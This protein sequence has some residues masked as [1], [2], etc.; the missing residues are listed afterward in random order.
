MTFGNVK[1]I[2]EKNLLESYNNEK[3][4]KKLITIK[5]NKKKKPKKKQKEP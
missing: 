4:F 1:S 2:I 3:E 5:E